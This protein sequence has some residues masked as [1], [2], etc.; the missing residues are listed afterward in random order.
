MLNKIACLS[1]LHGFEQ[2]IHHSIGNDIHNFTH[3]ATIL[4]DNVKMAPSWIECVFGN[5]LF[6]NLVFL[7]HEHHCAVQVIILMA[8]SILRKKAYYTK[9]NVL[10]YQ[11]YH[12]Y[13]VHNVCVLA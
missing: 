4:D 7:L 6:L 13:V 1:I 11:R 8:G 9:L 12:L 2:S 10:L 5:V 3:I